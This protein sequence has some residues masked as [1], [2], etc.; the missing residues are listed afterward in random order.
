MQLRFLRSSLHADLGLGDLAG[1]YTLG[2]FTRIFADRVYL[3]SLRLTLGLSATAVAI[4]LLLSYPAAYV[5]TRMPARSAMPIMAA[6]LG[7]S[8]VSLAIKILGMVI[9]FAEDGPFNRL[10]RWARLSSHGVQIIG[11]VPGVLFGYLH[12]SIPF[13]VVMLYAV[14]QTIPARLEEAA[15][16]HGASSADTFLRVI[17]PL[18]LPGVLS[19]TIFLAFFRIVAGSSKMSIVLL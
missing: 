1:A 15:L 6:I 5:L 2:N 19:A 8:F 7:S 16:I 10:L 4:S 3:D 12:L 14:L 17:W 9:I 13:M 18:S 11:T